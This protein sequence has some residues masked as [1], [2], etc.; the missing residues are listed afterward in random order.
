M[1]VMLCDPEAWDIWYTG[2]VEEALE[3]QLHLCRTQLKLLSADLEKPVGKLQCDAI[4]LL[5]AKHGLPQIA[6]RWTAE[7]E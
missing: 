6:K 3:L 5:F 2:S 1:P 7:L 4:N